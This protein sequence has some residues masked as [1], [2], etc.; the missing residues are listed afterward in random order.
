[1]HEKSSDVRTDRPQVRQ[2][3]DHP[4]RFI[5]RRVLLQ[6][7]VARRLHLVNQLEDKIESIEE[8]FD[9][10]SRLL[11]DRIAARLAGAIQ[12]LATIPPQSLVSLDAQ[13]RQNAVDP[14]GHAYCVPQNLRPTN[15]DKGPR[16]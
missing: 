3:T 12:L 10:R 1:T 2:R 7:G 16:L 4:F 15:A 13:R 8:T 6:N 9:A 5:R 14:W 11:R